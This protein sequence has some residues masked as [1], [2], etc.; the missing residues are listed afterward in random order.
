[1]IVVVQM[2]TGSWGKYW[3]AA[4]RAKRSEYS[5]LLPRFLAGTLQALGSNRIGS[6][7]SIMFRLIRAERDSRLIWSDEDNY[8]VLMPPATRMEQ[9]TK[10]SYWVTFFEIPA[11]FGGLILVATPFIVIAVALAQTQR[12]LPAYISL[13]VGVAAAV[14]HMGEPVV[15]RR[16]TTNVSIMRYLFQPKRRHAL[17]AS[18]NSLTWGYWSILL[19]QASS[20]ETAGKLIT[21]ARS[22]KEI[23]D[24]ILVCQPTTIT[25]RRVAREVVM[26]NV[27]YRLAEDEDSVL[28]FTSC[29]S[30]DLRPT[31]E[32]PVPLSG[33]LMMASL[34]IGL[35]TIGTIFVPSDELS[36]C[37]SESCANRPASHARAFVWLVEHLLQSDPDGVGAASPFG[38]FMGISATITGLIVF[39]WLINLVITRAA[40]SVDS[41]TSELIENFNIRWRPTST[42]A[43]DTASERMKDEPSPVH[44]DW[45]LPVGLAVG[46]AL[47]IAT[48]YIRRG[49]RNRIGGR[50]E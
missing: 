27:A 50:H 33:L 17:F 26:K 35:L 15:P 25:S 30:P 22:C 12:I 29:T 18:G 42:S 5:S 1:M 39:G 45:K 10:A 41:I 44:D 2:V 6:R 37:L 7:R 49:R 47:G 3:R 48:M 24:G 9:Y 38:K 21:T 31:P 40:S 46:A 43:R 36:E 16:W 13:I 8:L 23:T 20:P 19:L 32:Y 14:I 11:Y 28:V 34:L 4:G